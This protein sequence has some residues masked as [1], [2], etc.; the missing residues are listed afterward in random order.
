M[1]G[2]EPEVTAMFLQHEGV[3]IMEGLDS[4]TGITL[5]A[6]LSED[7]DD[8]TE[9]KSVWPRYRTPAVP[10]FVDSLLTHS[11][12][13]QKG[14]QEIEAAKSWIVVDFVNKRLLTGGQ[15]M[16][17]EHDNVFAMHVD[18]AG[19]YHWPLSVHLPPWW[20]LLTGV[21]VGMIS[22]ERQQPWT[23]PNVDRTILFGDP[24]LDYIAT[25][26][27][28]V[29]QSEQ[30]LQESAKDEPKNR[31][32]FT[33]QV[34]RDWLMTPR[35]DLGGRMPRQLL[36][37]ARGWVEKVIW[38]QRRRLED[39][40]PLVA[41][42]GDWSSYPT[43]PMGT[44]EISLYFNL[45]RELIEAGWIWCT[46]NEQAIDSNKIDSDKAAGQHSELMSFLKDVR[47][48]WL[49]S[50]FEGGKPPS[51]VIEC[52]RRRVP[53]GVGVP[54]DGINGVESEQHVMDCDCPI[55][56]MMADGAFGITFTGIDGYQLELDDEFA[57]SLY[58]TREEW[59]ENLNE[60]ASFS[61][62]GSFESEA[63]ET[64]ESTEPEDD[65]PSVW[66][67]VNTTDDLPGDKSGTLKMAFMVAEVISTLKSLDAPH[68]SIQRLNQLFSS[69]R[70]DTSLEKPRGA[71]ALQEILEELS[72][73]Y[74]ELVSMS[75][76]LQS[77]I[78]EAIRNLPY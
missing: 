25:N 19:D 73:T 62:T 5:I 66:S 55:C 6:L 43:A 53:R 48:N 37:G 77:Q 39:G 45:C 9:A 35:E 54:I 71:I 70:R 18:E 14:L 59:E 78:D 13:L 76:D 1:I 68:D 69:Y 36:H 20:E 15:F 11:V 56:E 34:H 42:P 23:K 72:E 64:D 41:M 47:D 33:V 50:S 58:E 4:D 49:E 2:E 12:S 21:S 63:D 27:L 60:F 30:W 10:E 24:L 46:K 44:E 16:A 75:A 8:W 67:G 40:E 51:L 57:F 26:V 32:P 38:G 65:F 3:S 74:P 22:Q 61:E 28:L 52:E 7:P 29:V 17:I 31:Y